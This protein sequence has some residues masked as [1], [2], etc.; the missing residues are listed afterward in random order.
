MRHK[1]IKPLTAIFLLVLT[2]NNTIANSIEEWVTPTKYID[3]DHPAI[4][5]AVEKTVGS[6]I[7][8]AKRAV[9]IHNF[10]RDELHFG[11]S[12][13]FYDQSASQVLS[14]GLGFC[15]TK[16]TL[17]VAMLRAA[18][19]P[20]RQHFVTINTEIIVDF[21]SPGTAFVDHSYVEVFLNGKWLY[22]DSYIVD[23][24]L[25][26]SARAALER[27]NRKIGYGIHQNGSKDWDGASHSFVQFVDDGAYSNFTNA[28]FGI[29]RDVGA[30]YE[31]GKAI[32]RL[33]LFGK[34]FFSI[35]KSGANKKIEQL[36]NKSG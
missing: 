1:F 35:A 34:L 18:G 11:W 24:D 25:F 7:D 27:E 26:D 12:S 14:A 4:I 10:V 36:R 2:V 16:G 29:Y 19:I 6:E 3:S 23:S 8:P 21:I 22:V 33:G 5:A 17:F 30:F 15:N 20:A 9:K 32:N 13:A 31:D 28:D